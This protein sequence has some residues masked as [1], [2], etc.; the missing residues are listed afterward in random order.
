M[1]CNLIQYIV[2]T[3][4]AEFW[5]I[6]SKHKSESR[7]S[8][9]FKNLLFIETIVTISVTFT[10]MIYFIYFIIFWILSENTF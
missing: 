3:E 10:I 6:F 7:C 4:R 2:V 9:T 5:I 8:R 1:T